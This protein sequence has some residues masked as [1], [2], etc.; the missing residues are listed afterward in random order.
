MTELKKSTL[1]KFRE[2]SDPLNAEV[3]KRERNAADPKYDTPVTNAKGYFMIKIYEV[4]RKKI[5]D[6]HVDKIKAIAKSFGQSASGTKAENPFEWLLLAVYGSAGPVDSSLR[7]R[8]K[9]MAIRL[10]YAHS[11]DVKP[12]ELIG[13]LYEA[14]SVTK[15]RGLLV[16]SHPD[17]FARVKSR[18]KRT[19]PSPAHSRKHGPGPVNGLKSKLKK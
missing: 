16:D 8:I 5:A 19:K 18:K 9:S 10:F 15:V 2:F 6:D 13:W 1:K 17:L 12:N 11:E 14:G 4:G 7:N 3:E